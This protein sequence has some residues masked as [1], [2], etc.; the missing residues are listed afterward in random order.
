MRERGYV[1]NRLNHEDVAEYDYRPGK[2]RETYRMVVVRKNISRMKGELCLMDEVRYFFYITT[3]RDLSAAEV[4]RLA[5]ARCDQE[6]VI[7]QLKNGVNALRVPGLRPGEQLGLH[8]HGGAGVEPQELVRHDD[9]PEVRPPEVRRH[10]VQA[11]HPRD[12]PAA[13]PGHPPG[14][15]DHHRP[16]VQ[17]LAH[18]RTDRLRLTP[19]LP[20]A[21]PAR[22]PARPRAPVSPV[23]K[24]TRDTPGPRTQEN[25]FIP[26]QACKTAPWKPPGPLYDNLHNRNSPTGPYS[27]VLGLVE[28]ES[29]RDNR[30]PRSSVCSA[31]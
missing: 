24:I 30:S 6:N 20:A 2:C 12:D 26:W 29:P 10:G 17:H 22:H 11:L 14:P 27:L 8:G 1:N 7:E 31:C 25:P 19:P 28:W 9:A 3:R 21:S 13:L 15:A 23:A 16:A 18:D 5:N 4:V